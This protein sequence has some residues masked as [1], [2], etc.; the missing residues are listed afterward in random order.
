MAEVAIL[1]V[2]LQ[3]R[4]KLSGPLG[5][6]QGKL[7]G[8]AAK[9][10]GLGIAMTAMGGAITGA[11]ALSVKNFVSMGDEIQKMALRTGFGTEALS[12][13]AFA[14]KISGSEIGAFEKGIK[15][16]ASFILDA[17]D[18]LSTSTD[19]LDRLGISVQQLE[20]LSPE[21]AFE[22]L[23][24]AIADV[25][26]ELTKAALA[27]DVFGKAGT[28]LLPLLN[29][30]AAGISAL[31]KEAHDLGVVFD[32]EAANKA[33]QLGDTMT[34]LKGSM[35]G[36]SLTIGSALA[37]VIESAV[38]QI[39]AV[40]QKVREWS[41]EHPQLT[42]FLV[43]AA[44]AVGGLMLVVGPLLIALPFLIAG[45]GSLGVVIGIATGPIGLIVLAIA[46]LT[47][48]AFLLR[49][50]WDT[51]WDAMKKAT[52]VFVNFTIELFNKMSLVHRHVLAGMLDAVAKFS[53]LLGKLIP[54]VGDFADEIGAVADKI[55][56]G[57]PLIDITAEKVKNLGRTV[58]EQTSVVE[59]GFG[60]MAAAAET[61]FPRVA[62]A[63]QEA[64]DSIFSSFK[65]T[66]EKLTALVAAQALEREHR[67]NSEILHWE[68]LAITR[69]KID[70]AA[71]DDLA[72][73]N[74][75]F[76]AKVKRQNMAGRQ[77]EVDEWEGLATEQIRVA[78][79]AAAAL[80]EI[81]RQKTE[82]ARRE[83]E[84]QIKIL[85]NSKAAFIRQTTAM[86]FQLSAQGQA[87]Q[88]LGGSAINVIEALS[89]LHRES[90]DSIITDLTSQREAGESWKDLLLRL[91]T[92][93]VLSLSN[94]SEAMA[95][96]KD[97]TRE[98][99]QQI[100]MLANS[101]AAFIRQTTAMEFQLSAQGQAWQDLGGSAKG[102]IEAM[103][104]FHNQSAESIIDDLSGMREEGEA[105]KD[106]LLRLDT[107]GVLSLSNLSEAVEDFGA[108]I[109]GAVDQTNLLIDAQNRQMLANTQAGGFD[110]LDISGSA[111]AALAQAA[112]RF[113]FER[114][115]A[116][117]I[118][119]SIAPGGP[120]AVFRA[121]GGPLAAGQLAIVGERGPELFRPRTAGTVIPSGA[122]TVVNVY[123]SGD[124][125]GVDDLEDLIITTVRDTALAGGGI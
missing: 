99:E 23:S 35:T 104:K 60:G 26:D 65:E 40:V 46:A 2:L 74:D 33:A 6:M 116:E 50:N 22:L 98:A 103:A 58:E 109:A 97:T 101:K 72:K 68:E 25:P 96:F 121:H 16:M 118:A 31:R 39:T 62:A 55:R 102:V 117:E 59:E 108:A 115:I 120:G 38:K 52:E 73:I 93:G 92:E 64:A 57:M 18:G 79:A 69:A 5:T 86:E 30:G 7:E 82:D 119:N 11:A 95:I 3:A 125:I 88:D 48:G 47:A 87:W 43:I 70:Q 123:V 12:E 106:L 80:A 17:K 54:K 83:A 49:K 81:N 15:R 1:S 36:L 71:A 122:G 24:N 41:E 9:A 105:W 84:Q 107:E 42:K 21:K 44:A 124:V 53:G 76:W 100:K 28:G 66:E 13:M 56:E 32:Q 61:E 34:R 51:I 113:R 14:L 114:G 94:L 4:D 45:I 10:R 78:E 90:T 29:E 8:V 85:A 77:N 110:V 111:Q 27:Q 89:K 75:D 91:D 63:A 67:I 112:E 19:A 37:P 20:G